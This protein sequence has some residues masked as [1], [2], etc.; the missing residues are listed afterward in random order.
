MKPEIFDF[1]PGS[2]LETEKY[3]EVAGGHFVTEKQK[4]ESCIKMCDEKCKPFISNLYNVLLATYLC[5]RLFYIIALIN[6]V[7]TCL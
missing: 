2:L 3:I 1:I 6:L 5:G 7:H 4:P